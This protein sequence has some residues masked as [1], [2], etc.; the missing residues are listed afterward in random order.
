MK[1]LIL[2]LFLF[3]FF[4]LPNVQGQCQIKILNQNSLHLCAGDSVYLYADGGCQGISNVAWSHGKTGLNGG[5]VSPEQTTT[6]SVFVMDTSGHSASDKIRIIV[7]EPNVTITGQDTMNYYN[8]SIILDAGAGYANY[9]WSA[10]VKSRTLQVN[11]S[12]VIPGNNEFSVTTTDQYGCTAKDTFT[13]YASLTYGIS[14]TQSHKQLE[15]YPNP[16]QGSFTLDGEL[17]NGDYTLEIFSPLGQ[18]IKRTSVKVE[19]FP[20]QVDLPSANSGL[21]II[22]LRNERMSMQKKLMIQ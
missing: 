22:K 1:R 18:V 21:Y 13:V 7:E 16:S 15:I 5:W 19:E 9:Q 10:G 17:L 6:Y 14:N 3:P 20:L 2:L 8:G 12:M 11:S 4:A